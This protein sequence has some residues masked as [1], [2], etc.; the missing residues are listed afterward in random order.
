MKIRIAI[1]AACVGTFALAQADVARAGT[2][3]S[4]GSYSGTPSPSVTKMNRDM[5]VVEKSLKTPKAGAKEL[6][7]TAIREL[8][9]KDPDLS[10]PNKT[11]HKTTVKRSK[12]NSSERMGGGG[13]V[14]GA[15]GAPARAINLNS[16]R[17]NKY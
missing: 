13:G 2:Y 6:R 15:G 7:V 1:L 9:I 12:S 14:R 11:T 16:S 4:N 17:S 5:L 3:Q 10:I 8:L